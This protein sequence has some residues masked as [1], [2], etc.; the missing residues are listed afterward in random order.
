LKSRDSL[1]SGVSWHA[2]SV[3]FGFNLTYKAMSSFKFDDM[4]E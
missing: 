1:V 2:T 3:L 4:A